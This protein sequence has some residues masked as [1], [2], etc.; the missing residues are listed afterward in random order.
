VVAGV[1]IGEG[2][3]VWWVRDALG[4]ARA[5]EMAKG[6]RCA[7]DGFC[8]ESFSTLRGKRFFLT[9]GGGGGTGAITVRAPRALAPQWPI[10]QHSCTGATECPL[11]EVVE[12]TVSQPALQKVCNG[13]HEKGK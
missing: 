12:G 2:A 1:D 7:R 3:G 5:K 10:V 9:R 13:N 4:N 8:I 6:D 11:G